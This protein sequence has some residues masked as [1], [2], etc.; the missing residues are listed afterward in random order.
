MR[1]VLR[2]VFGICVILCFAPRSGLAQTNAKAEARQHHALGLASMKNKAFGEAIAELNQA[3]DLGHDFAVLY[4]IG[5]AYVAMEQPVFAVKM[6]K[7][8]LADGGK[9]VPAARRKEA[10][11]TLAAQQ[12]RIASVTIHATVDGV[13]LRVDG[14]AV[15]KTPLS[16]PL[17]LGAGPHF[18]SASAEGY[19][20]WNQPLELA[21]GEK[22]D[23][24]IRLE[25]SDTTPAAP[26]AAVPV[27]VAPTAVMTPPAPPP[28][29]AETAT[30]P[31]PTPTPF[32]TRTV[33]AY[34]LGGAGIA[35]LVVGGV[36]GVTAITDRHDSNAACPQNQCTQAG[37]DLNNQAK[38]AAHVADIGI[39]VGLVSVAVA[40]YLLLRPAQAEAPTA[41][42]SAPGVRLAAGVGPNQASVGLRGSW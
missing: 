29:L 15:G 27:P 23:L 6:L 26:V 8:Y 22:R 19:R 5:Q 2:G 28:V 35:A 24:E 18:L 3:Y 14:L 9:Q 13:V 41:T 40:T 16:A 20:P 36:Y 34:A 38:T 31:S 4:D 11:A 37:V 1:P 17:E 7:K 32:P 10:E 42:A 30:A 33:V 12:W 21:C 25:P 39:G